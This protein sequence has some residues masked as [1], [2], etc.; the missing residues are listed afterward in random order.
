[1]QQEVNEIKIKTAELGK[2]V[3]YIKEKMDAFI[4]SANECFARKSLE[5]DVRLLEKKLE[6][7][8]DKSDDRK[9]QIMTMAVM[10]IVGIVLAALNLT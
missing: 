5:D 3:S 6:N 7:Q 1:M 10:I 9:W 4:S 8:S 2:D